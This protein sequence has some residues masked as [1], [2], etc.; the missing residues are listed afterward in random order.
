MDHLLTLLERAWTWWQGLAPELRYNIIGGVTA[1]II[2]GFLTFLWKRFRNLLAGVLLF[3]WLKPKKPPLI[4]I[5]KEEAGRQRGPFLDVVESQWIDSVLKRSLYHE[6]LLALNLEDRADVIHPPLH[7]KVQLPDAG[8]KPLPSTTSILDIFNESKGRLLILGEPGSGKTITLLSLAWGLIE[9]ARDDKEAP[10]PVVLPLASWAREQKPLE[11]WVVDELEDKYGVPRPLGTYWM[12]QREMV[13]LLDGLDEV[14]KSARPRCIEAI[15]AYTH[16]LGSQLVVCSRKAEYE[17]VAE[18][19][20]LAVHVAVQIQSLTSE[21]IFDYLSQLGPEATAVRSAL[22]EDSELLSLARIP[23]MLHVILLAYRG[24]KVEHMKGSLSLEEKRKRIF[25]RY[26]R[27]V[28]LEHGP[29]EHPWPPGQVLRW[30]RWIA[31]GLLAHNDIEFR[32]ENLQPDWLSAK[33]RPFYRRLLWWEKWLTIGLSVGL[34]I[35][36]IVKPVG[37]PVSKLI[38]LGLFGWLIIGEVWALSTRRKVSEYEDVIKPVTGIHW[39]I[40]LSHIAKRLVIQLGIGLRNG[41]G[42]G[43]GIGLVVGLIFGLGGGLKEG[44]KGLLFWLVFGLA[45][46]LVFGLVSGLEEIVQPTYEVSSL[47]PNEP[48]WRSGKHFLISGLVFGLVSGLV[49][50]LVGG[51]GVGLVVGL[52]G[53]LAV[54]LGVGLA[55]GLVG[56]LVIGL[57]IGLGVGLVRYGG[58]AFFRHWALRFTLWRYGYTPLPWRCVAFLDYA[59]RRILLRRVGGGWIFIHRMLMEH[60]VDLDDRFMASLDEQWRKMLEAT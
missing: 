54:G 43:L 13:L 28:L 42:I 36:P 48:I 2:L 26:I 14:E 32:L 35:A 27:R 39:D 56:V 15:N 41:L 52:G 55:F 40:S 24:E 60:I 34:I 1:G 46:A 20:K 5:N 6:V 59:V 4:V 49:G 12:E 30:L 21:Q 8:P 38:L 9:R 7:W 31:R 45:G 58:E 44:L 18:R 47:S 50:G 25:D 22:E 16:T 11:T 10:L 51:L 17:A 3:T 29:K 53:S 23:L 37:E 33:E 57:M 19:H